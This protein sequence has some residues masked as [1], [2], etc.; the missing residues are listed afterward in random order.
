MTGRVQHHPDSISPYSRCCWPKLCGIYIEVKFR[1]SDESC[2]TIFIFIP[3][4]YR[5]RLIIFLSQEIGRWQMIS[6]IYECKSCI[7]PSEL[8]ILCRRFYVKSV[9][10]TRAQGFH[11]F[12]FGKKIV[13]FTFQ[14]IFKNGRK[15]NEKLFSQNNNRLGQDLVLIQN[16]PD[17]MCS[18]WQPVWYVQ[19][20]LSST[21]IQVKFLATK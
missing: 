2:R 5:T 15:W 14:A 3:R 20:N 1:D 7:P 8:G 11:E 21:I 16:T 4:T 17:L 13:Y 18:A 12:I 6:F 9:D 19:P 10:A